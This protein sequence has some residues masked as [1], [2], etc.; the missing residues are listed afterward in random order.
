M[1][2]KDQ[3]KSWY[4]CIVTAYPMPVS[5]AS[6]A[7]ETID[8]TARESQLALVSRISDTLDRANIIKTNRCKSDPIAA[9]TAKPT[10]PPPEKTTINC[11]NTVTAPIIVEITEFHPTNPKPNSI[12]DHTDPRDRASNSRKVR[13]KRQLLLRAAKY[14]GLCFL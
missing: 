10:I 11:I 2:P 7:G 9:H 13:A 14:L 6:R 12:Q 4:V 3:M 8:L 5:Q 1:I